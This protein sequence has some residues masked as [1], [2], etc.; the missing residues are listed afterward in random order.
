MEQQTAK[1]SGIGSASV[2]P[3][4]SPE[5][6]FLLYAQTGDKT[7]IQGLIREY[8]DKA[9][10][11]ARRIIGRN[12]GAEDAV[13]EAY[14]RLISTAKR[15]DGSVPFAAWLGRLVS[16]AAINHHVQSK[17]RSRFSDKSERG[18]DAM[19][20][21]AA[22]AELPDRPDV[23]ALRAAFNTLPERYRTPI[24]M[25]YFGGLNQRETAQALGI[26]P[27]T[28]AKQLSRAV[29]HL[30]KKL[31]RAGFAATSASV[32]A[33]VAGLPS[34]SSSAE[35][36]ASLAASQRVTGVA[37]HVSRRIVNARRL[38]G[39]ATKSGYF[40]LAATFSVIVSATIFISM[41]PVS[42]PDSR[43][44]A[45]RQIAAVPA[46]VSALASQSADSGLIA[47][48]A[49][50]EGQ[51]DFAFDSSGNGNHGTLVNRPQWTAGKFGRALQFNG[52]DSYVTVPNSASI[53][54][55]KQHMT[56]ATW[57]LKSHPGPD[58]RSEWACIIGRRTGKN[59]NDLWRLVYYDYGGDV[60]FCNVMPSGSDDSY[61]EVMGPGSKADE[62]I[63]MHIACVFDGNELRL[64][65][66]GQRVGSQPASM[67]L[68][69]ETTPVTIGASEVGDFP[70]CEFLEATVDDVRVYNRAC[71]D[72]ELAG[73]SGIR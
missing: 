5:Q 19:R 17:R 33:L 72:S 61:A 65:R 50:D 15:Y 12:D 52:R 41:K 9:Y 36:T 62:H 71:T 38:P 68:R 47:H 28:I 45:T 35:F 10:N 14:L 66:N 11:H 56:V 32:I 3:D 22:P 39:F 48:W 6:R 31:A 46:S 58:R 23:E 2:V 70:V 1:S 34:Y 40:K 51:G 29:D 25:Y 69:D 55:L 54:S 42:A 20:N 53:N 60:Y 4:G 57:I 64:Y 67:I 43:K 30:R 26:A 13:Q 27:D 7:I 21:H 44:E 73:L 59:F 18:A 16:A 49:F 37:G 63:W 24:A 8:A